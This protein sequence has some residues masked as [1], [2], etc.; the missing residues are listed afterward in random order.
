MENQTIPEQTKSCEHCK[1]F[2][3]HYVKF[4]HNKYAPLSCGHCSNPHLRDKKAETPACH[5]FAKKPGT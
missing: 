2:H 3:R 4:G 5:R 1:H